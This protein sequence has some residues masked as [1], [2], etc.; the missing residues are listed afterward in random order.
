M[1]YD[2]QWEGTKKIIRVSK[3]GHSVDALVPYYI[4][5]H[6]RFNSIGTPGKDGF[7]EKVVT[8]QLSV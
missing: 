8:K 4:S 6:L 1:K 7:K 2:I 5:I 3:M